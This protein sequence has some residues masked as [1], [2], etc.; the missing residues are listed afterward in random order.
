MMGRNHIL[1]GAAAGAAMSTDISTF[2]VAVPFAA[3][4]ALFPDIDTT[5]SRMGRILYPIS[6]IVSKLTRHRGFTHSALMVVL[7]YYGLYYFV[8]FLTSTYG[9]LIPGVIVP[10][11]VVGHV[12]HMFADLFSPRGI[13]LFWPL[14]L[15]IK[16]PII[17]TG[18][19]GEYILALAFCAALLV[20]W[21][22][23]GSL[24]GVISL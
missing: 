20:Y 14:N 13:Q 15:F 8:Q 24:S 18:G 10:A 22:H 23:F 4:G 12:S 5:G 2:A 16:I 19:F 11:F 3:L 1:I 9:F 7:L 21:V 6:F 17:T